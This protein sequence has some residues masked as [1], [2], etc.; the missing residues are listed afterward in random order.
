M[1]VA[2]NLAKQLPVIFKNLAQ[3]TG[4]P[5][6]VCVGVKITHRPDYTRPL[7][8][9]P[10]QLRHDIHEI[11]FRFACLVLSIHY[12]CALWNVLVNGTPHVLQQDLVCGIFRHVEVLAI[13]VIAL[14]VRVLH[15]PHDKVYFE[16]VAFIACNTFP[17]R[18]HECDIHIQLTTLCQRQVHGDVATCR[19]NV[20]HCKRLGLALAFLVCLSVGCL[21][22]VKTKVINQLTCEIGGV[23]HGFLL[24]IAHIAVR[25]VEVFFHT[26]S[27]IIAKQGELVVH[28]A[29]CLVYSIGCSVEGLLIA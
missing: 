5:I 24:G 7:K 14:A 10:R 16:I 12:I 21:V 4:E 15:T 6:I 29:E 1:P 26:V 11:A 22:A 23:L 13:A 25:L 19:C 20:G 9:A 2:L 27:L 3:L 17:C 18:W 28:L 8:N